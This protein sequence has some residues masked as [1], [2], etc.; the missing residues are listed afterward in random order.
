[1]LVPGGAPETAIGLGNITNVTGPTRISLPVV[2]GQQLTALRAGQV[3][4]GACNH[5]SMT[6]AEQAS[7]CDRS[8]LSNL[9]GRGSRAS[10][11]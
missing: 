10:P 9:S 7:T 6:A 4:R 8:A 1:M 11:Q 3:I 2:R 5:C